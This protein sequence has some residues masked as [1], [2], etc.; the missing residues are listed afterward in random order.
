MENISSHVIQITIGS[1]RIQ[2]GTLFTQQDYAIYSTYSTLNIT[3]SNFQNAVM[4]DNMLLGSQ[5]SIYLIN[6]T[7][8]DISYVGGSNEMVVIVD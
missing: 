3:N 6:L 4:S 1:L 5:S 2:N 8:H 7:L